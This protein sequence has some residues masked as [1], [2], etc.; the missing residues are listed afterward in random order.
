MRIFRASSWITS[1]VALTLGGA[2]TASAPARLAA[3]AVLGEIPV[4]TAG[5]TIPA[6]SIPDDGICASKFVE[7]LLP[8]G[9]VNRDG[10]LRAGKHREVAR[11]VAATLAGDAARMIDRTD[12]RFELHPQRTLATGWFWRVERSLSL[13]R[14]YQLAICIS[15]VP[16]IIT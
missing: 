9:F 6:R 8:R 16:Q 14:R 15:A 5:W 1:T 3:D 4:E 10:A 13:P 7:Q 12:P 2:L 11:M